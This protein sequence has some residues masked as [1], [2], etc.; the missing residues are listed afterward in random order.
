MKL[1]KTAFLGESTAGTLNN[2]ASSEVTSA[3]A[4]LDRLLLHKLRQEAAHEGIASA[5][6]VHQL[7]LRQGLHGVLGDLA[8]A[9][10]NRGGGSLREH[11]HARAATAGL[12]LCG[13][14]QRDGFQIRA[15]I[16]RSTV[17]FSLRFVGEHEVSV[18]HHRSHLIAEELDQEGSR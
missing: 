8:L 15:V 12:G 2:S 10:H 4:I 11:D 1:H 6:G 14:L 5:V 18:R 3:D 17:C 9:G 7:V 13:K 16:L